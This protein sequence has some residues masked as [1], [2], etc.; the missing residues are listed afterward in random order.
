[1]RIVSPE[2]AISLC[3]TALG[4]P[5][6]TDSASPEFLR[7]SLR[8]AVAQLAPC[9]SADLVRFV[10][11]PLMQLSKVRE[12]VEEALD[13]LLTYGDILEMAR[14]R[15]DPWDAP[16]YVL[17][18]APPSFVERSTGE[19]VILGGSGDH[20]TPLPAELA[21]TVRIVGPLRV[22]AAGSS[23]NL[24]D[25]LKQLGLIRLSEH[26][27]L[28]S[29]P[30][31]TPKEHVAMWNSELA[32]AKASH[33]AIE[34]LEVLDPNQPSRYYK[35]RWRQ[36]KASDDGMFV[37]RRPQAYG[38]NLWSYV[39]VQAG[40]PLRILDFTARDHFQLPRDLAWRLQAAIDASGGNPQTFRTRHA[41]SAS[42]LEFDAPLPAFAE[43]RLSL[44]SAKTKSLGSLFS[45]ELPTARCAAEIQALTTT[46]WLQPI[47]EGVAS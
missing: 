37:A 42:V 10:A 26:A 33:A 34:G 11:E 39:E 38:A 2:Q 40:L 7:A 20:P 32:H 43:R 19:I 27:W 6:A 8:R 16:T 5:E 47:N 13:E 29:P 24:P 23:R 12:D 18:P 3:Q 14:L 28:R 22:L 17:R 36:P 35:G 30:V 9:S 25:D 41:G 45:F 21:A 1:M 31:T 44:V 4:I 46:L 15:D